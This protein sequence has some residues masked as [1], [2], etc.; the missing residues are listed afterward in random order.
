MWRKDNKVSLD[1]ERDRTDACS[2]SIFL[3]YLDFVCTCVLLNEYD[4]I[5]HSLVMFL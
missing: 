3:C 1:E 5:I 4:L 2:E